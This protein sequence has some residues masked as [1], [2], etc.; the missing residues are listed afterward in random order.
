MAVGVMDDERVLRRWI[1]LEIGKMNDGVVS[2]RVPLQEL[3]D[4]EKPVAVT[5]GGKEH[6]FDRSVLQKISAMIT[7][8]LCRT[9]KLPVVFYYSMEVS[10]SCMLSDPK[11]LTAF[12]EM[13]ELS[14]E[15]KMEG[16]TVWV[17][18]AIVFELIRK[19]PTAVQIMMR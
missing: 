10:D 6:R 18:R 2:A 19:Y 15:R 9:L 16:G 11:A 7:P 13:G 4:M 14:R 1:S 12:Q 5:R 17:G 8:E 3:L